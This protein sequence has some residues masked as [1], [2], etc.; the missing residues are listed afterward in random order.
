MVL[1]LVGCKKG[2]LFPSSEQE[3]VDTESGML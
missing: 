3:S 1:G 2:Y